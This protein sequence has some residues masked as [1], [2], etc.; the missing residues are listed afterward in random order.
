MTGLRILTGAIVVSFLIGITN[1]CRAEE[2]TQSVNSL[3]MKSPCE[4]PAALF[5]FPPPAKKEW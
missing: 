1:P 5:D 3:E 4:F 2:K